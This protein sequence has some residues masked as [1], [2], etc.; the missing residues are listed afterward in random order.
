[1]GTKCSLCLVDVLACLGG[2]IGLEGVHGD[3]GVALL[4]HPTVEL[5]SQLDEALGL[6]GVVGEVVHFVGI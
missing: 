5:G 6:G 2:V 3:A 1:M 4:F